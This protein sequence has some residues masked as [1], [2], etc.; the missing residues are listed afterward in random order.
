MGNNN[1]TETS[2]FVWQLA[3]RE[4]ERLLTKQIQEERETPRNKDRCFVSMIMD[5]EQWW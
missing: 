3:Q 4:R 5:C 1:S 2:V